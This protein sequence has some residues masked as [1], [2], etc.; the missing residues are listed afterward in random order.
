VWLYPSIQLLP[1]II[2][3]SDTPATSVR[4]NCISI[5]KASRFFLRRA[6]NQR[7]RLFRNYSTLMTDFKP[8][9]C[10]EQTLRKLFL[11]EFYPV[12]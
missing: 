9:A 12:M 2:R 5:G 7:R 1:I 4:G 3:G 8:R 10:C 6:V 11:F